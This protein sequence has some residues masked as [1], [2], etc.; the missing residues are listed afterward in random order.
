MIARWIRI[1]DLD[2]YDFKIEHRGGTLHLNADG[3]PESQLNANVQEQN[4]LIVIL[5][6]T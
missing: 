5:R 4:I 1:V 3:N 2:M 6:N